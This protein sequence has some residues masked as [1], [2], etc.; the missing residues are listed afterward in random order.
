V[1]T[2]NTKAP[3]R[4]FGQVTRHRNIEYLL[5]ECGHAYVPGIEKGRK[6]MRC[7]QCAAGQ[8]TFAASLVR[9][10]EQ[11]AAAEK[12]AAEAARVERIG[13]LARTRTL[14]LADRL[15]RGGVFGAVEMETFA[16]CAR[17]ALNEQAIRDRPDLDA[18]I[19]ERAT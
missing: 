17:A 8:P 3:L 14:A 1:S 2:V 15:L 13:A 16:I 10:E 4:K 11:A 6:A 9:W 7:G 5:L 12:A 19:E 18:R